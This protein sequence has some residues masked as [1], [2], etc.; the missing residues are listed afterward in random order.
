M[1]PNNQH[2]GNFKRGRGRGRN[3]GGSGGG[4]GGGGGG[5]HKGQN[6]LHRSF[7]STGPEVKIRGTAQQIYERYQQYARDAAS[8]G[9]RIAAENLLQHAEHYYRIYA[10]ALA[11]SPQQTRPQG[12]GGQAQQGNDQPVVVETSGAVPHDGGNGSDDAGS[13]DGDAERG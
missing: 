7:E 5:G 2:Q 3:P 9:D 6:L 4:G 11:S 12:Q 1:R 8:A 10:A 13:S